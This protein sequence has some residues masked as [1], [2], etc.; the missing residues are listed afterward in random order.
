[1]WRTA[2]CM[3]L[4]APVLIARRC[5]NGGTRRKGALQRPCQ[6]ARH[7]SSRGRHVTLSPYALPMPCPLWAYR[8]SSYAIPGTGLATFLRDVR[9]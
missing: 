5:Y 7:F 8:L 2:V 6:S 1:M 9:Y 3:G 4:R